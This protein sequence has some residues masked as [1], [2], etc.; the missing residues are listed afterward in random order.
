MLRSAKPVNL[1]LQGGGAHGAFTWGVLDRLLEERRVEIG[2][3]SGTSAG[4]MNAVVL[5]SGLEKGGRDGARLALEN[6]WR[7]VSRDGR[8]SPI[9]RGLMDRLLGN[10]SLDKN[11]FF[12]AMDVATRF[13]SPYDFNPFNI[14]PLRDVLER[15]VD[16]EALRRN[17]EIKIFLSATNV[18][19]GKVRVFPTKEINADVVMASACLPFLFK[20]VEIDG[21]PYWDGGYVGN[22]PLFP[23]FR[24]GEGGDILLVQT[25]PVIR[26]ETPHSARDILNRINE[27]TFNASLASE[28]RAIGFVNRMLG[29]KILRRITGREVAEVRLHRIEAGE[30]LLELTSSSKFNVD[31]SFF[32]HLRDIGREAA[33]AFLKK[34][35][36][37]IGRRSTLDLRKEAA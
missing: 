21:T 37:A 36:R 35:Y 10:W 23:F 30:G 6:F 31:W 34:N 32:E 18:H 20:A 33:E 3:I 12:L 16:F 9:Q 7:A 17:R 26:E 2:A 4:A 22:P 8:L 19:T 28:F 11:P 25:N 1:A 14:N 13:V 15:E 27:I 29:A 24:S 5:A